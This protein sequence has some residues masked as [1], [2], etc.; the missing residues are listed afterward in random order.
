MTSLLLN[1]SYRDAADG[2]MPFLKDA[3]RE[4]RTEQFVGLTMREIVVEGDFEVFAVSLMDT[5]G[6]RLRV[7]IRDIEATDEDCAWRGEMA[8]YSPQLAGMLTAKAQMSVYKRQQVTIRTIRLIDGRE[9]SRE[10]VEQEEWPEVT[11]EF[12]RI[13]M[14]EAF[15]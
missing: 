9:V 4:E 12:E 8:M 7:V 1:K 6:G 3:T 15:R 10:D 11:E 2:L 13:A 5:W 14:R